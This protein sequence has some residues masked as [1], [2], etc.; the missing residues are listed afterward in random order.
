MPS[1]G[2]ILHLFNNS[3]VAFYVNMWQ[4]HVVFTINSLALFRIFVA[5]MLLLIENQISR[6]YKCNMEA[7]NM[8]VGIP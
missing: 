2:C 7:L 5:V 3:S 4:P 1:I 6:S 8:S